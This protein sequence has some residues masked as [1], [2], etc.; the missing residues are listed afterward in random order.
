VSAEILRQAAALM[1]ERAEACVSGFEAGDEPGW[2]NQPKVLAC[3]LRKEYGSG[4]IY[5]VDAEHI[6]SWHPAVALAVADWLEAEAAALQAMAAF[7][8][9][10]ATVEHEVNIRGAALT[11]RKH[12]K[13]RVSL[14][15][16]TSAPA[17]A[18]ARA[19]LGETP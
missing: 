11:I 18:V 13:G 8:G 15:A 14:E 17:L 5:D 7:S 16:D 19:Y 6:A 3:A 4:G 1:R 9:V 10:A 2:Y 12:D